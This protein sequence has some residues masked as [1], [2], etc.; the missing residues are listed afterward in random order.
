MPTYGQIVRSKPYLRVL[1]GYRPEDPATQTAAH[2]VKDGV[3]INSGQ[4][5]VTEW[6]ATD[7]VYEWILAP[8]TYTGPSATLGDVFIAQDDSFRE[9]VVEAGTLV[10]LSCS[11][12]FEVRTGYYDAGDWYEGNY[13]S[14]STNVAGNFEDIGP[15]GTAI[16]ALPIVGQVS[17]GSR[18]AIDV[19]DEDSSVAAADALVVQFRTT[20]RPVLA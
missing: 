1:R 12:Q 8:T 4:A 5:I 16:T 13:V 18:G 10:G 14:T 15:D 11:G 6:N 9:D 20:R 2:R 3:T 7:S 17:G 19:S